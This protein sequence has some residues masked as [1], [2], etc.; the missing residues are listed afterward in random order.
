MDRH[1]ARLQEQKESVGGATLQGTCV[2]GHLQHLECLESARRN[3][4]L[5]FFKGRDPSDHSFLPLWWPCPLAR[6]AL[7]FKPALAAAATAA[8][9]TGHCLL[10]L[11]TVGLGRSI[12]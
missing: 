3:P 12:V 5:P 8:A 11:E 7:D 9:T 2:N 1:A 6:A 10:E 4:T